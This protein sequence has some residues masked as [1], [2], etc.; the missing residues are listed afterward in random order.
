MDSTAFDVFTWEL[1]KGNPKTALAAP[2]SIVLTETAAR[3]YFGAED[4]MG[5]SLKGSEASGRSAAGDYVV[6]GVMKDLPLNSHF[7][8]ILLSMSTLK[9]QTGGIRCLGLC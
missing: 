5:K 3:K 4:P 2:Y 7:L 9:I 1:T 6:T 8:H